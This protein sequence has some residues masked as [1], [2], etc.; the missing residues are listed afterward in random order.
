MLLGTGLAA[1]LAGGGLYIAA[2][3]SWNRT[4]SFN[5]MAELDDWESR[6]QTMA[7]AGDILVGV[8]AAAAVGWL[9]WLLVSMRRARRA[10]ASLRVPMLTASVYPDGGAFSLATTF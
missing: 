4:D 6:Y 9:V 10:Q 5:T 8:G 2:F 3:A 1:A 7:L